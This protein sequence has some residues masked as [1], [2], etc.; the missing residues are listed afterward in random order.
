MCIRIAF[1]DVWLKQAFIDN[2]RHQSAPAS[3]A[4]F[5]QSSGPLQRGRNVKGHVVYW[6]TQSAPTPEVAERLALR[7][8][9]E[10]SRAEFRALVVGAHTA[11]GEDIVETACFKEPHASGVVHNN[12][13]VRASRQYRWK[14]IAEH[15]RGLR[16]HVDFGTNVRTW[17]EG[18]VYGKVA[19]EHKPPEALDHDAE[20]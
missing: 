2:D 18:V 17:A 8:P 19:S 11:C 20:Q 14:K 6:I 7:L 15:L 1:R 9:S 10:F 5:S 12:V 16:V 3:M 13:L 4:D